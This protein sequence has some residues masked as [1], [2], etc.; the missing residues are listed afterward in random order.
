MILSGHVAEYRGR[1]IQALVLVLLLA[2]LSRPAVIG[3]IFWSLG[4]AA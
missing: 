1:I 3:Y 4:R 2:G